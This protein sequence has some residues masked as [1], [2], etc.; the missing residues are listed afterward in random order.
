LAV[1]LGALA[2]VAASWVLLRR[3][4]LSLARR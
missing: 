4:L 2:S 3:D 1:P